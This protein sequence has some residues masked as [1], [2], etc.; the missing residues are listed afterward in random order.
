MSPKNL[1]GE[2]HLPLKPTEFLVLLVLSAEDLHG[3]GIKKEVAQ[4]SGGKIDMEPGTLYRLMARLVSAGL[5]AE[6]ERRPVQD[7]GDERRRYYRIT[8]VGRRTVSL[9]AKRLVQL[10]NAEDVRSLARGA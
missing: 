9:E 8:D 4:R 3:Y 10:T 7:Q 1:S 2:P 5:I 6:A